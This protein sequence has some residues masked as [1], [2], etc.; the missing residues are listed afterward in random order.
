MS[1]TDE[2]QNDQTNGL[3]RYAYE[4]VAILR[5]VFEVKKR[6]KIIEKKWFPESM[7]GSDGAKKCTITS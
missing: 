3:A 2:I 1:Y 6:L 4:K 5:K 7:R